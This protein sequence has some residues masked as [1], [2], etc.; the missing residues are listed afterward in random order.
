[1]QG[2][3]YSSVSKQEWILPLKSMTSTDLSQHILHMT[4]LVLYMHL[5]LHPTNQMYTFTHS[6]PC[7]LYILYS[8]DARTNIFIA[9]FTPWYQ[10]T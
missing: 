7:H 8:S 5:S 6:I 3:L 1:M 2:C 4:I 9:L 10:Q